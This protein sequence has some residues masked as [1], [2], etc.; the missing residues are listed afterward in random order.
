MIC[1]TSVLSTESIE[2]PG[3]W[4]ERFTLDIDIISICLDLSHCNVH[5]TIAER[6]AGKGREP[7][8]DKCSMQGV[9]K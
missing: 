1:V 5:E 4:G 7:V 2:L 8:R 9:S 6:T 3:G